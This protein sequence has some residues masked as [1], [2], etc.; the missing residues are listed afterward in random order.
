V[1][2]FKTSYGQLQHVVIIGLDLHITLCSGQNHWKS[3]L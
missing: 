1:V 2:T 3:N